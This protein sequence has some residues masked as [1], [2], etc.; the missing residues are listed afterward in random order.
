MRSGKTYAASKGAIMALSNWV[1]R[2]F[3]E[4]EITSNCVA[5]GV[6]ETAITKKMKY[7]LT[8]KIIK[9]I[10]TPKDIEDVNCYFASPTTSYT[11]G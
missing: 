4:H 1:A 8:Q 7:D 6:T 2:E 11:T 5:T 9:R 3:E 10:G